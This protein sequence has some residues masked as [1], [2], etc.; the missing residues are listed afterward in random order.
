MQI[1]PYVF[2]HL[3]MI[4]GPYLACIKATSIHLGANAI[5]G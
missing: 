5:D 4:R 1:V 3:Y 2:M